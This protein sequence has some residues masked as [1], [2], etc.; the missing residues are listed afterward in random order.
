MLSWALAA[1]PVHAQSGPDQVFQMEF[2]HPG[3]SPSHWTLTI[4]PDGKGHFRSERGNLPAGNQQTIE[5]A[6][7][8]RDIWLS[9]NFTQR[10]FALADH[11]NWSNTD[12]ESH[13]KVAFQG[14]KKFSYS[15]PGVTGA[16]EFNYAKDKEIQALGDS[17]LAVAETIIEG[18][19]LETLLLHDRL[20]LDKEMENLTVEV[21]EGRA[22]QLCAIDGIL[23]RLAEDPAVMDRVRKRATILLTQAEN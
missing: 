6:N 3:L 20:G 19:R 10:V 8:D 4:H 21:K 17:L 12:C 13:L 5:S 9:T 23:K 11:R 2:S 22:Q 1:I 7:V 14:W 15:S 18:A 16:C